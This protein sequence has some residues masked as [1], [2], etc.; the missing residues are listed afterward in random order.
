MLPLS[1]PILAVLGL[2]YAVGHWNSYFNA[3]VYLTDSTKYPLQLVL[4][5]YLLNSQMLDEIL[6]AGG[7]SSA[8]MAD[9]MAKKEVLKYAI[10]VVAALPMILVYPFIQR[11][12]IQ[13]VMVGSLKG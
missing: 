3:L 11:F 7:G 1:K 10:I 5:D 6:V 9:M 12:F 8:E 13:G 4:R 2:Y